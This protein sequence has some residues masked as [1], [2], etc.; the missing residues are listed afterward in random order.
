MFEGKFYEEKYFDN[1]SIYFNYLVFDLN[2]GNFEVDFICLISIYD[3]WNKVDKI[4]KL[5]YDEFVKIKFVVWEFDSF[6]VL[7]E[8]ECFIINW[9]IKVV[10]I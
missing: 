2:M 3:I 9:G 10:L 8:V 1:V 7:K 6:G 5:F 4:F